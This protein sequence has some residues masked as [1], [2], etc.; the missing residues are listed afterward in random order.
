MT[1]EV[2]SVDGR[3]CRGWARLPDVP[4][5]SVLV[6]LVV[7]DMVRAT[8]IADQTCDDDDDPCSKEKGWFVLDIPPDVVDRR[9]DLRII[10][11]ES[12]ELLGGVA[13]ASAFMA[14]DMPRVVARSS[15]PSRALP[16]ATYRDALARGLGVADILNLFYFDMFKRPIDSEALAD[17][18]GALAQGKTSFEGIRRILLQS[19]E[20]RQLRLKRAKAA[21]RIFANP[22][23]VRSSAR[24][25]HFERYAN[26]FQSS[27]ASMPER[28]L[29]FFPGLLLRP[30]L[31]TQLE[32]AAERGLPARE[33]F[34][35]AL[36]LLSDRPALILSDLPPAATPSARLLPLE[37]DR[38]V[39]IS[40]S[41][42][43]FAV[44]WHQA[45]GVAFRW[46]SQIGMI[47]NP[48]PERRVERIDVELIGWYGELDRSL[49]IASERDRLPQSLRQLDDGSWLLTITGGAA[50]N[51]MNYVVLVAADATCPYRYDGTPDPRVLSLAVARATFVFEEEALHERQ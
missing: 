3:G 35:R 13:M 43:L 46:M 42:T 20:Y 37:E 19:A 34:H 45:E 51:V 49:A 29:R 38:K 2:R 23:V 32:L 12:G 16:C 36:G 4:H 22:L 1:G 41:S 5:Y 39:T 30:L 25:Q 33:V 40:A 10:V 24:R 14:E 27:S 50:G 9:S 17:N 6:H 28:L 7:D 8:A 44:G 47:L 18:M 15:V 11:G 48:N 26:I 31:I 21:G